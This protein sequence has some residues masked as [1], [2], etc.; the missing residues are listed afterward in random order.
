M[1]IF[2]EVGHE[3]LVGALFD[4]KSNFINWLL[5]IVLLAWAIKKYMPAFVAQQQAAVNNELELVARTR[6][7][8]ELAL[9]KQKKQIERAA[10][11]ADKI[12]SDAKAVGQ[13]MAVDLQKQTEE[14]ISDLRRKFDLA[15][16]NERKAALL[17][18]RTIVAKAAIQLAEE[19]LK[20][21]LSEGNKTKI[22]HEFMGELSKISSSNLT[23][24]TVNNGQNNQSKAV[25]A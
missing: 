1:F 12:V 6:K 15:V 4:F 19:N 9:A 2:A 10:Q 25:K 18:M 11:D 20:A 24:E 14:E 8:A 3:N 21:S 13:R 22:A 23:D 17:E 16:V 5:L 7:E